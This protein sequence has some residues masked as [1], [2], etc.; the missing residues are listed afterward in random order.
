MSYEIVIFT[1]FSAL[2]DF[3]EDNEADVVMTSVDEVVEFAQKKNVH[4]ILKLVEEPISAQNNEIRECHPIFKY[5][6]GNHLLREV[7]GYCATESDG[8]TEGTIGTTGARILGI[9]SPVGR[10]GKTT[11]ALTLANLLGKNAKVLYVNLEEYSG[12]AEDVLKGKGT[13][14]SEIMY[15]FRRGTSGL[16]DKIRDAI[17][18]MGNFSYISPMPYPEDVADVMTEEWKEFLRFLAVKMNWDYI[19]LDL[20]NL[21]LKSY[22]LFDLLEIIFVP[23]VDDF[24][25]QRKL[26]EFINAMGDMGRGMLMER[27]VYVKLPKEIHEERMNLEQLEWSGMGSYARKIINERGL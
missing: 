10:C 1:E 16:S 24:M 23:E 18:P 5:Q 22:M 15:M 25:G 7:T 12:L 27:V 2:Q 26:R 20:G 17:N 21:I 13:N 11:F 8:T 4:K 3:F 14:L 19:V 6:S 9:Y